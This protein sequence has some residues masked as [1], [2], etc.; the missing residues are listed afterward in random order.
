MEADVWYEE[1]S[2]LTAASYVI[3]KVRLEARDGLAIRD[4]MRMEQ[5]PAFFGAAFTELDAWI[6][7]QGG[8]SA[9][10]GPPFARYYSVDPSVVDVEVIIPLSKSVGGSGRMHAVLLAGGDAVQVLHVGPYDAMVPAYEAIA[11]WLRDNHRAAKEP[12]REVYLTD[13]ASEPDP[14]NWRTLVVQPYR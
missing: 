3:E 5:L 9:L 11:R 13:P 4:T 12:P 1:A 14:A 10:D 8:E 2:M 6:L 7:Q